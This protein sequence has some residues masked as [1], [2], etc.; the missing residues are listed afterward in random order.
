MMKKLFAAIA[1]VVI[2]TQ[3]AQAETFEGA[4]ACVTKHGVEVGLDESGRF[5][6][7]QLPVNNVLMITYKLDF[8]EILGKAE[9]LI[10]TGISS[11]DF[12]VPSY[13]YT[14]NTNQLVKDNVGEKSFMINDKNNTFLLFEYGLSIPGLVLATENGN[15]WQAASSS[16]GGYGYK[17]IQKLP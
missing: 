3:I 8:N 12:N 6:K 15:A 16:N 13:F 10:S 5:Y 14:I 7:T 2:F 11:I 4:F 17:H 1:A 9:I